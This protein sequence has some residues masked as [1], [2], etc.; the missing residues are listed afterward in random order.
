MARCRAPSL[1]PLLLALRAAAAQDHL[2]YNNTVGGCLAG[3]NGSSYPQ[4]ADEAGCCHSSL[5]AWRNSELRNGSILR[6]GIVGIPPA[7]RGLIG[8]VRPAQAP[9]CARPALPGAR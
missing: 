8:G 7:A 5:N 9:G 2:L 3:L 1:L 6:V 4:D